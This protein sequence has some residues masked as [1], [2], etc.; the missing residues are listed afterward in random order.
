M[1]DG[2]QLELD[3]L[4][5]QPNEAY[6]IYAEVYES[7]DTTYTIDRGEDYGYGLGGGRY[8]L[9]TER[10]GRNYKKLEGVV[11]DTQTYH[12]ILARVE[13][14]ARE[15]E[16]KARAT[17]DLHEKPNYDI[18]VKYILEKERRIVLEK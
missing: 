1:L 2:E 5:V 15:W 7:W 16:E 4:T 17:V 6:L 10:T 13:P 11:V 3:V 8:I 14:Y 18:K 12:V 9:E